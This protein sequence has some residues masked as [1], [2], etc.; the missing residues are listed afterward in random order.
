MSDGWVCFY[1]G[2]FI[3]GRFGKSTLKDS[4]DGLVYKLL[5]TYGDTSACDFIY[6]MSRLSARWIEDYGFSFGI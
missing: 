3:S 1:R 6:Q 5:K 4:K 2:E